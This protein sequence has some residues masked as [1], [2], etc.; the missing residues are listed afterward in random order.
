MRANFS[1]WAIAIVVTVAF[2]VVIN[3]G[4]AK[5]LLTNDHFLGDFTV[6]WTATRMDP[7][8]L[9]DAWAMTEAQRELVGG[10]PGLRPF[11]NPPAALPWL[12]PFGELPFVPGLVGW[13]VFGLTAYFLAARQ[14]VRGPGLLLLA[15]SPLVWIS[16]GTGQLS[17][18]LGAALMTAVAV[19]PTRPIVAGVLFGL[20]ATVK[21]HVILLAPLALVAAR[22]W[23]ALGAALLAGAVVGLACL[24]LQGPQLW[25]DWIEATRSFPA[26]VEAEGLADSGVTPSSIPAPGWAQPVVL[27]M[28]VALGVV[29]VWVAFARSTD[30]TI[31]LMG[32]VVGCLL[33]SPYGRKYDLVA[34]QPAAILLLLDR[35]GGPVSW[36]LG[37]IGMVGATQ[38]WSVLVISLSLASGR[39]RNP[40]PPASEGADRIPAQRQMSGAVS[41]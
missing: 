38:V 3:A 11:T 17:L 16:A 34:L 22:E 27:A 1:A 2:A 9:Y 31:R 29:T 30:R 26:L 33:A 32:L 14:Y 20:A 7:A 39:L 41:G 5:I 24:A 15:I 25:L 23:R 19:L 28:G 10:Q 35:R 21:P 13:V 37:M 8:Q 40:A 12:A 18:L 36:L 4:T 6:F